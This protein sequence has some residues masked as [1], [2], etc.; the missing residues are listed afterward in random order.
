MRNTPVISRDR[1]N[2]FNTSTRKNS[3][4]ESLKRSQPMPNTFPSLQKLLLKRKK[5]SSRSYLPILLIA[6]NLWI[7]SKK[8]LKINEESNKNFWKQLE[9]KSKRIKLLSYLELLR[10]LEYFK[11]R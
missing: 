5:L 9:L 6:R 4:S 8:K 10:L 1:S 11:E 2:W 7:S 3:N